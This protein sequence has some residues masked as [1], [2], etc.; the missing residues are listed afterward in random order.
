MKVFLSWSGHRSK[1]Y[2]E[3]FNAHLRYMLHAVETFFSADDVKMGRRWSDEI[4]KALEESEYGVLFMTHDNLKAEWVHFESG[5]LSKNR[6]NAVVCPLLFDDLTF[7][8]LGDPLNQF[9]A[10][11]FGKKAVREVLDD[12]NKK[13][14]KSV[15]Q[16]VLDASFGAWW[17]ELNEKTE[18]I[19]VDSPP[20]K[21]TSH[22]TPQS[23]RF[24]ISS[25]R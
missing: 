14:D 22:R 9:Q 13:L 20:Q 12:L 1:A 24:V 15:S 19:A 21:S 17:P 23:A 5:A 18:K 7:A 3:A 25:G 11:Q 2:A 8:E 6:Q 16:E 10:R 4:A